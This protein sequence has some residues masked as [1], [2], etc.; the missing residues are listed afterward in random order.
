[1]KKINFKITVILLN[2]LLCNMNSA[3]ESIVPN[4]PNASNLNRFI[5]YPVDL[6]TGVP[7][8]SIPLF[9][10]PT[11]SSKI[12]LDLS[13][14]YHISSIVAYDSLSGDFG[15]GW[16]LPNI[17]MISREDNLSSRGFNLSERL[18][19][20]YD[21][22][23]SGNGYVPY[24]YKLKYNFNFF[25]LSGEFFLKTDLNGNLITEISENKARLVE[26]GVLYDTADFII[27]GFYFFDD[28]GYKYI[29]DVYDDYVCIRNVVNNLLSR[30]PRFESEIDPTYVTSYRELEKSNF[31]LS[32]IMDNN[33]VE[34]IRFEYDPFYKKEK[35]HEGNEKN[36]TQLLKKINSFGYGEVTFYRNYSVGSLFNTQNDIKVNKIELKNYKETLIKKIEFIYNDKNKLIELK[37]VSTK[38]NDFDTYKIKY[39]PESP[40]IPFDTMI[41]YDS[42][43]YTNF[44]KKSCYR[45]D[46]NLGLFDGYAVFFEN[47]SNF[48][49][50]SSVECRDAGIVE[51]I[52]APNGE[53]IKYEFEPNTYSYNEN[54]KLE[55]YKIIHDDNSISS[56]LDSNYFKVFDIANQHNF[57][58][59]TIFHTFSNSIVNDEFNFFVNSSK[60]YYLMFYSDGNSL[61]LPKLTEYTPEIAAQNIQ[62]YPTFNFYKNGSPI[63]SFDYYNG[64]DTR[65]LFYK[66]HNN[67]CNGPKYTLTYGN[68]R[69]STNSINAL[70]SCVEI[71]TFDLVS[72]NELKIYEYGWGN[73]IKSIKFY[74]KENDEINQETPIKELLF[75]YNF[76][77]N[78]RRSS[79]CLLGNRKKTVSYDK[80]NDRLIY[81]IYFDGSPVD[82]LSSN[83]KYY[84]YL[85]D[86]LP[87]RYDNVSIVEKGKNI[88]KSKTE[89]SL[90]SPIDYSDAGANFH[91]NRL[92]TIGKYQSIKSYDSNNILV[93]EINYEYREFQR[94]HS[95]NSINYDW[96]PLKQLEKKIYLN[97]NST[98]TETSI[99]RY[100]NLNRQLEEEETTGSMHNVKRINYYYH[101][102]NSDNHLNRI[103]EIESILTFE[104]NILLSTNS[105]KYKKNW[106]NLGLDIENISYL[107]EVKMCTKSIQNNGSKVFTNYYDSLSKPLEIQNENGI[108][109]CYIWGYR[110]TKIVAE[111][112]NLAYSSI[113]LDLILAIHTTTNE[114]VNNEDSIIASLNN[115]RNNTVLMG[116]MITTYTYIPLVG[117]STITDSNGYTIH[118]E[119][120]DFGR[121]STIKDQEGNIITKNE[122]HYKTQ[123]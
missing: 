97:D 123:N 4:T 14:S 2:L 21:K 52:I 119:Y 112:Q 94:N 40:R 77:D 99:Y 66:S 91:I 85:K 32:K 55:E 114:S 16:S 120:D 96:L 63:D 23:Q 80:E 64:S 9:T 70:N 92:N 7:D 51:K 110:N 104:N 38:G 35:Y 26:I 73:R 115:L 116:S 95:T 10:I 30:P 103:S 109:T 86:N 6:S 58:K 43:G 72:E 106:L 121:L 45:F 3:Q 15:K 76:F 98:L 88:T 105:F 56:H 34:L 83:Y 22:I 13:L 108:K 78:L 8:I 29:F 47:R 41:D 1:M 54:K 82:N 50:Y 68:Y 48:S 5:E 118:Y 102:G 67:Y 60:D 11:N 44:F 79:G 20:N 28:R 37:N 74:E 111:I 107:P 27:D 46:D 24:E 49:R 84:W 17:G 33:N 39:K 100:N 12:N 59:T 57:H 53:C 71:S 117:V 62:N 81:S 61:T 18:K 69:I 90:Y 113:P 19:T 25:D 31:R 36:T 42:H 93:E 101:T 65:N 122:Y 87:F 75:N 89:Y